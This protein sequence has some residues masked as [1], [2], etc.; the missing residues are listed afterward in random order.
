M[1]EYISF[2]SIGRQEID[3]NATSEVLYVCWRKIIS[4]LL[5]TD[6]L[7]MAFL[8]LID[9][10]CRTFND[11]SL[12]CKLIFVMYFHFWRKQQKGGIKQS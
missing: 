4:D 10:I 11:N 1:S 9:Q 2:Q 3:S 8:S 5:F 7:K 12:E 6:Q